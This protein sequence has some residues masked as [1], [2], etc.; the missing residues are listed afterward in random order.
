MWLNIFVPTVSAISSSSMLASSTPAATLFPASRAKARAFFD[1]SLTEAELPAKLP[2]RVF[3]PSG[4]FELLRLPS[5]S[6]TPLSVLLP[7]SLPPFSTAQVPRSAHAAV[8]RSNTV[9][10]SPRRC[11]TAWSRASSFSA[12]PSPCLRQYMNDERT[13]S[14]KIGAMKIM[15][16]NGNHRAFTHSSGCSLNQSARNISSPSITDSQSSRKQWI[17]RPYRCH[18]CKKMEWMN[19]FTKLSSRSSCVFIDASSL[20]M[21]SITSL[22]PEP[23]ES[24][25]S[26]SI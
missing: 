13:A 15:S 14:S 3:D 12:S 24:I 18:F 23:A 25:P 16:V 11:V 20:Q 5:A 2:Q 8:A 26:R 22:P 10:R 6:L 7:A 17:L 9:L 21:S 4:G 1:A 19:P